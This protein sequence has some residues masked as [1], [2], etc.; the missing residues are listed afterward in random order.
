MAYLAHMWL[1]R[2]LFPADQRGGDRNG[3]VLPGM[4]LPLNAYKI[5]WPAP[6]ITKLCFLH[7]AAR[8]AGAHSMPLCMYCLL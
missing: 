1:L 8:P 3:N 2:R 5:M 6:H 7:A 4:E